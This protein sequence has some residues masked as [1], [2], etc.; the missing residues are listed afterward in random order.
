MAV[1]SMRFQSNIKVPDETKT[2]Y[3][4]WDGNAHDYPHWKYRTNMKFLAIKHVKQSE[5]ATKFCETMIAVGEALRGDALTVQMDVG[6]DILDHTVEEGDG[7]RLAKGHKLLMEKMQQ[8][9]Y[10]QVDEEAKAMYTEFHTVGSSFAR[11]PT[12]SMLAYIQRRSRAYTL[13]KELD[14]ERA[15]LSDEMLGDMLLDNANLNR[16][17]KLLILTSTANSKKLT[18][19]EEALKAQ[20]SKIHFGENRNYPRKGDNRRGYKDRKSF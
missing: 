16:T 17:E 13:L 12:E 9:V 5:Y 18:D 3:V 20:H 1:K 8:K 11:Q 19:I 7:N 15:N 6:E 10:P 2:G 14:N 4:I